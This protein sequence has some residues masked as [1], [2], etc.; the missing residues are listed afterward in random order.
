MQSTSSKASSNKR[1]RLLRRKK[2]T[3]LYKIWQTE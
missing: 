2:E 3:T 1:M